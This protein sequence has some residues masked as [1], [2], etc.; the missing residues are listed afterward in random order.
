MRRT[1]R[2][3]K[4]RE[5]IEE[6]IKSTDTCRL[7]FADGSV[8]YIVAMNF[9]FSP[10]PD[11][12]YF[13]CA[14]EGRKLEMIKKNN[15]ACFQMDTDHQLYGGE[16][17]CDWGMRFRS[18]TGY[19]HIY[20]VT[21]KEEKIAALNCIMKKY[22]GEKNYEYDDKLVERTTILRFEISEMTAKKC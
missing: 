1:E 11:T 19:G 14:P 21:G 8:P 22:G 13:H 7:A 6:I 15:Y 9:G 20:F 16:K 3:I 5:Q 17:G 18:I 12:L 2:E 4:E 10:E